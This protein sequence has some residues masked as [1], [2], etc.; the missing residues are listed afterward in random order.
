MPVVFVENSR[1]DLA[2]PRAVFHDP[3]QLNT[4]QQIRQE[5]VDGNKG[6]AERNSVFKALS[7]S[8]AGFE[9][10]THVIK[11]TGRYAPGKIF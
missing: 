4:V 9:G 5:K 2:L 3:A 7:T 8:P 1:A 11:V 6:W 10:C